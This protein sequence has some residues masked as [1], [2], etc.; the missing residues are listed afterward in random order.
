MHALIKLKYFNITLLLVIKNQ[1][2]KTKSK[3]RKML[4]INTINRVHYGTNN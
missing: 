2:E 1:R 4:I 3:N